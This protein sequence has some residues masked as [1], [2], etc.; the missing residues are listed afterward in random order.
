MENNK[1]R[2]LRLGD[3]ARKELMEGVDLVA[4]F[5]RTTLGPRGRNVV[6]KTDP[7]SPPLNTND[8]VSIAREIKHSD[9]VVNTGIELARAVA[10]KTS[11]VA[12]D[13][14]TTA[15]V[16]L[17]AI[18]RRGLEDIQADSDAVAYR[19]G[20]Q[21][22]ADAIVAALKEEAEEIETQE[23][24]AAVATIS[25]NDPVIG[26]IVGEI[27]H[28]T[29][30]DSLVTV[31]DG[32][33][34]EHSF[35]LVEGVELK[36]GIQ[37]NFFITDKAR[38]LAQLDDTPVFVTDHD[39]TNALETV[40]IME[41]ASAEGYKHAAVVAN[42]ITGEAIGH[43]VEIWHKGKFRL[44]P[45]RVSTWGEQGKGVLED[46]AAATGGAIFSKEKGDK[47]PAN[48]GESIPGSYFG[49]AQKLISTRDRTTIVAEA[50]DIDERVEELEAQAENTKKAFEKDQIKERIARLKS[51]VGVLR[52]GSTVES[53]LDERRLRAQNAVNA[54]K[55]AFKDGVVSGGGTA[56]QRA[57]ETITVPSAKEVGKDEERGW[58]ACL[59]AARR[60]FWQIAENASVE[61]AISDDDIKKISNNRGMAFDF[62]SAT[63]VH[64]V[65]SGIV[66]PLNVVSSA[67]K[68]AAYEAAL[69]LVTEGV[70]ATANDDSEKL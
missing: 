63:T 50:E 67:I 46:M 2:S 60:P 28:K 41:A 35:E 24:L 68:N 5:V 4:N 44:L 17:Q 16:L 52:L 27:V 12:G 1:A 38:Q 47:L 51:G 32:H 70:V 33:S 65:E 13:G 19:R 25:S 11:D 61:S 57:V 6:I 55:A 39:I 56:L 42:N 29:G 3:D 36:G 26:K 66:D 18:L 9:N 22:A 34:D 58:Y 40:K 20:I 69:F 14:T 48:M 64:G 15:T 62:K 21:N 49:Y 43:I 37:S 53:E 45:I 7:Y 30:P 31:E 8:G 10:N 54:T 59:D 23:A